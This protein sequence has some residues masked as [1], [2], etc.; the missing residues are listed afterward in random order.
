MSWYLLHYA[1]NAYWSCFLI[2][3]LHIDQFSQ[4][5]KKKIIWNHI[6]IIH[7]NRCKHIQCILQWCWYFF[8]NIFW[9]RIQCAQ[10]SILN[11]CQM[12][13]VIK[14][15]WL[16]GYCS[17]ILL[18]LYLQFTKFNYINIRLLILHLITKLFMYNIFKSI[19]YST[20]VYCNYSY[21]VTLRYVLN[22]LC[23]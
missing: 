17:S 18:S 22:W 23:F 1:S 20:D 15:Y 6:N 5:I 2:F 8:S 12:H 21:S 11:V 19:S 14:F 16:K 7:F 3:L 4:K 10:S 13:W 9:N